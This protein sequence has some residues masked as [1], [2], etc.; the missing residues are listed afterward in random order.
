MPC[1]SQ[2]GLGRHFSRSTHQS[3]GFDIVLT[4]S[5]HHQRFTCVRL[6]GSH[7]TRSLPRLLARRSPQR[8]FTVAARVDLQ[9]DPDI[10]LREASSHL[11]HSFSLH[12]ACPNFRETMDDWAGAGSWNPRLRPFSRA[13]QGRYFGPQGSAGTAKIIGCQINLTGALPCGHEYIPS[14]AR[15]L[16]KC[17]PRKGGSKTHACAATSHSFRCFA[18]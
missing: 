13:P 15:L 11:R 16:N 10:R 18:V 12:T 6:H 17:V 9:P 7:L 2:T 8:L 14:G 5:T 1:R 3:P 4:F